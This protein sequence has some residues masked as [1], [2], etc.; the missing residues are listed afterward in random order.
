MSVLAAA[1]APS[2]GLAPDQLAQICHQYAGR[3]QAGEFEVHSNTHERW[4]VQLH[5]DD[6]VDVWLISWTADQG[7]DFH[8][9]GES[10]GAFTVVQGELT[11]AVWA[12]QRGL[13]DHQGDDPGIRNLPRAQGQTVTFGPH[14]VHDVRNLEG[15]VA[16]SVHAYSPPLRLMNY[17]QVDGAVL[18]RSGSQWTSDPE[19]PAPAP[20]SSVTQ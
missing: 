13:G 6:N 15:P 4:H 16:V 2:T 7:T 11:E 8:D 1:P 5:T 14:Y 10:A 17:Y 20:E 19:A 12:Q 3:V 18:R 9:H